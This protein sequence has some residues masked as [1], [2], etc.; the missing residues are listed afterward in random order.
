MNTPHLEAATDF[1]SLARLQSQ[2]REAPQKALKKVSKDFEALFIQ[3]VLDEADKTSFDRDFLHSSETGLYEGL[4]RQQIAVLLAQRKSLGLAEMIEHQVQKNDMTLRGKGHLPS[5]SPGRNGGLEEKEFA[6]RQ[7][8]LHQLWPHAKKAG[9][10]LGVDPRAILAQ[11][12]LETGWGKSI[13]KKP[14]GTSSF[15]LFN[16]KTG[17]GWKGDW[18]E[19]KTSEYAGGGEVSES[20]RFRAYHSFAESFADY[21]ALLHKPRYSKMLSQAQHPE[22]FFEGLAQ[23]GY[24][25]DPQYAE[26]LNAIFS[27]D[28][29]GLV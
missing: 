28:L 22:K 26:K 5:L 21:V 17:G 15:N 10:T 9:E 2:A 12:A 14:D 1:V 29:G 7:D 13:I 23:A 24:A 19:A 20:A 27:E 3:M 18:V 16:I 8:F 11:A 4:L 6:S 25:T